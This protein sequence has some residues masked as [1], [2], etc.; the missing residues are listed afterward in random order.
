[1][2][3]NNVSDMWLASTMFVMC[4]MYFAATKVSYGDLSSECYPEG[5]RIIGT[6]LPSGGEQHSKLIIGMATHYRNYY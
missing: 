2:Y 6:T 5:G 3:D 1:M 4:E